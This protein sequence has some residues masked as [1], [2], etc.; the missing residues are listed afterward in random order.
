MELHTFV[1]MFCRLGAGP[2]HTP[3]ERTDYSTV[4]V[5]GVRGHGDPRSLSTT[6]TNPLGCYEGQMR[7]CMK[8]SVWHIVSTRKMLACRYAP[9]LVPTPSRIHQSYPCNT[10]AASVYL[11]HSIY[12][13][14]QPHSD[15]RG[16]AVNGVGAELVNLCRAPRP[17][18]AFYICCLIY[19][20][21]QLHELET[22]IPIS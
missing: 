11:Y 16:V 19:V 22:V 12:W 14:S 15:K 3:R 8:S 20:P 5:P 10:N 2:T 4:W 18:Q 21:Q 7:Q 13:Y 9:R 6:G 17:S 1:T